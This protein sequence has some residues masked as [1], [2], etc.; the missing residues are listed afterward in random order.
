MR[1]AAAVIDLAAVRANLRQIRALAG[2]AAVMAVV[3]A[4]AYGHGMG[5]VARAARREGAEW[6]GVA[7]P[8]EALALRAMGDEGRILAWLWSPGDRDIA[9]CVR[10]GIDLS[11][12]SGWALDE[13]IEASRR[14]GMRAHVQVKVDTGLSRNGV[15]LEQLPSLLDAVA[16]AMIDGD[17]DVEAV[18]SHLADGDTPG[19]ESVSRQVERYL[20][21]LELAEARGIRPRLRHLSNSGGLWAHPDC[22]FD[23]V[24][25]GI[26]MYG[27]TPAPILGDSRDLGLTPAMSLVARLAGIKGVEAGSAVSY[28]GTWSAPRE[29]AL[30]LVPIG[31]AD[32]LPRAAGNLLDVA[33]DGRRYPIV[34]RVA[35]D[36][37]VIDLGAHELPHVGDDVYVFGAGQ[38]GERTADE[39]AAALDTIG[40]EVVTRIGPRVQREYVEEGS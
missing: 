17:I 28:G 1:R 23:L 24:R 31:Y 26:A 37:F 27:L 25:T 34:G 3:K 39:W 15:T 6:L 5:P 4:D 21:A 35:M 19:S 33:V 11:V 2:N 10:A 36:Q 13:V 12:S 18:W 9:A 40:Y 8:S 32:G 20:T 7:L 38:H 29:T 22:R 14:V 30:G 16:Q